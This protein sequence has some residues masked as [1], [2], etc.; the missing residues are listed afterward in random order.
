MPTKPSR[1][2][3]PSMSQQPTTTNSSLAKR[4][5]ALDRLYAMRQFDRL[6]EAGCVRQPSGTWELW[7]TPG[8]LIA[9]PVL[10]WSSQGRP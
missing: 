3:A 1:R 10:I 9:E 8:P 6:R 5:A 2:S 4:S 7:E